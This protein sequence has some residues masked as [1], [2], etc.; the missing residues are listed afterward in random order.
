MATELA[1]AYVQIIP[2]AQ[3]ISGSI[4]NVLGG[5]ADRA[6]E[7]A[8]KGIA[9]KLGGALAKGVAALG[10]GKMV[11]DAIMGASEFETTMAKVGTL[12]TGTGE[13][14]E[15]LQSRIMG[16]SSET[17]MAATTLGEAAYSALSASVP[18][19][20]LGYI[21]ER[22][23]K[24]A[25]AGFTDVDTALSATAKTMN[26]YGMTGEDAINRVQQVLIQT[27][28]KGITTVGELGASLAQV[29]PTAAA[30]GVSFEQVGA[31]MSL[32]T[33]RGTPTAQATTQL[34]SAIA[35]LG[36]SG[37]KASKAFDK[38]TKGTALAG[39]S[40]KQVMAEGH[41]LGEVMGLLQAYAD[42]TGMSMVD[43]FSSIEGG[44][45]AMMIASDIETF[46]A[47][48]NAMSEQA[49]VV[50]DAYGKMA[51]TF[52]QSFKSVGESLKNFGSALALGL[53]VGPAIEKLGASV[54]S[55]L[56]GNLL[57]MLGNLVTGLLSN[58]PAL[59][60]AAGK[61]VQDLLSYF[62]NVD[63]IQ[64]GK[65]IL[66]GVTGVIDTAGKWLLN[67]GSQA[68]AAITSINWGELG[69]KIHD[70]AVSLI[71]DGGAFLKNL[72]DTALQAVTTINW[73]EVGQAI[74]NG[75]TGFIDSAGAFLSN[76]FGFGKDATVGI[77]WGEIGS[78]IVGTGLA[79]L[80]DAGQFLKNLF[81]Q[82]LQAV[83]GINW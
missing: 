74:L 21:L 25:I 49:D 52:S 23:S 6:G 47:D 72:F 16:L 67:L 43:L 82:G 56:T 79:L 19:E 17:G 46:N 39:K 2:S 34:R 36:K 11:T 63:W 18:M 60:T 7:S 14:F 41:D 76:L 8:G 44:N 24:L 33:A 70:G 69:T 38:A 37:T 57:P 35:E 13:E 71:N 73:S 48:L 80:S 28:N 50:G 20:D 4:S 58:L 42:K 15:A 30:M 5:E 31:A 51:N 3:G 77:D 64:V 22:S 10:V 78:T 9:G 59:L 26:A 53:D 27:Q 32:M 66:S 62:A 1:K 75:V 40:F 65:S 55:F 68:L 45:A 61:L 83:T 29:T 54:S 81:D 12:F